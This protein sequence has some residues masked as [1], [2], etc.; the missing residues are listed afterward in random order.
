MK[1][2]AI[3]GILNTARTI[4]QGA[5]MHIAKD[6]PEYLKAVSYVGISED[7][8]EKSG[9]IEGDMVKIVSEQGEA[10]VEVKKMEVQSSSFF[11]PVSY[12]ANKLVSAE[13]HGTGVPS[14]KNTEVTITK[15]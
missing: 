9:L 12:I 1:K 14:F 15:A 5:T 6:A 7:D 3:T 2:M 10:V 8:L 4:K 11:M 13:T